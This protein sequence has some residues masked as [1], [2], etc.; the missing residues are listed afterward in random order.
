MAYN[1]RV[2]LWSAGVI[3]YIL[4][5]GLM[6][7]DDHSRTQLYRAIVRGQYSFYPDVRWQLI[8]VFE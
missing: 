3:C 2:D 6:P 5:S 1:N 7:F 4:L 8:D